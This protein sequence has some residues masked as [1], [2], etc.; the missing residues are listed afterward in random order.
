MRKIIMALLT[1]C[2]ISALAADDA[3][4]CNMD[5]TKIKRNSAVFA[6]DEANSGRK[7]L[8]PDEKPLKPGIPHPMKGFSENFTGKAVGEDGVEIVPKA[9]QS[10]PSLVKGELLIPFHKI[11]TPVTVSFA[12]KLENY[13]KKRVQN[14][15]FVYAAGANI[16]FRGDS[17]DIRYYDMK[18][19]KYSRALKLSEGE[20]F[21]V[22]IIL[23]WRP[24]PVFDLFIN[25]VQLLS[26]APQRG[27]P[28]SLGKVKIVIHAEM[29]EK[30]AAKPAVYLKNFAITAEKTEK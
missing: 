18:K 4:I 11:A 16:W 30:S 27:K 5:F 24:K 8:F 2:A 3:V 1:G 25:D 10:F 7:R 28:N 29:K 9:P 15:F 6:A 12:L 17:G 23:R 21:R 19:R 14:Y 26:N 20:M 22:K 13:L